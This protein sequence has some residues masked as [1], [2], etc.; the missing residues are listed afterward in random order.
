[1]AAALLVVA[2]TSTVPL[3]RAADTATLQIATRDKG[4]AAVGGTYSVIVT[5]AVGVD[6]AVG[7]AEHITWPPGDYWSQRFFHYLGPRQWDVGDAA[8]GASWDA[9]LEY[10]YSGGWD[11]FVILG[12]DVCIMPPQYGP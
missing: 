4:P 1:V 6:A 10:G 7:F 3:V 12:D 8:W 2:A 11:S 5:H 9:W